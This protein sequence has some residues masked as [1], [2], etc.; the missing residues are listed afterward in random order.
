[1]QVVSGEN[2]CTGLAKRKKKVL[3][4][5]TVCW[6]LHLFNRPL[7]FALGTMTFFIVHTKLLSLIASFALEFKTLIFSR[8]EISVRIWWRKEKPLCVLGMKDFTGSRNLRLTQSWKGW[9][10]EGQGS[11]CIRQVSR[12]HLEATVNFMTHWVLPQMISV[13]STNRTNCP[14]N[15]A[16]YNSQVDDSRILSILLTEAARIM[17]APFTQPSKTRTVPPTDRPKH[18]TTK[19]RGSKTCDS[20]KGWQWC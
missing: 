16:T 1:M 11:G 20:W 17:A 12:A 13:C 6:D 19:G 15:S 8:V 7:K 10:S 4:F 9:S 3:H 18:R 2:E 5:E 14:A